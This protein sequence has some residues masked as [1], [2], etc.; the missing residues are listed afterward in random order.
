MNWYSL[1]GYCY[2]SHP[3]QYLHSLS[4]QF[5]QLKYPDNIFILLKLHKKHWPVFICKGIVLGY[6]VIFYTVSGL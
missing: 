4:V 6:R 2:N 5:I 1:A 3:N